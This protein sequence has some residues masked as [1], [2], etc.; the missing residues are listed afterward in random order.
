MLDGIHRFK[1]KITSRET[2]LS[3]VHVQSDLNSREYTSIQFMSRVMIL[4]SRFQKLH[5]FKLHQ[6]YILSYQSLTFLKMANPPEMSE[7]AVALPRLPMLQV[8]TR[9]RA[10]AAAALPS[11]LKSLPK[12]KA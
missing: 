8:T 7:L 3:T 1:Y 2:Y 5:H 11:D 12:M 4:I 10:I 9:E 6:N